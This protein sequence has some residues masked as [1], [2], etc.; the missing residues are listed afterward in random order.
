MCEA[1][2]V[3]AVSRILLKDGNSLLR[4][5]PKAVL[6]PVSYRLSCRRRQRKRTLLKVPNVCKISHSDIMKNRIGQSLKA[7]SKTI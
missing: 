1:Q 2:R 7:Q 6:S 3:V 5:R 4:L